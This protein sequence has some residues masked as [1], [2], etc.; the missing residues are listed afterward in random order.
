MEERLG[1]RGGGQ[2]IRRAPAWILDV[3]PAMQMG[4]SDKMYNP[5]FGKDPNLDFFLGT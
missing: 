4:H 3:C 1:L 2:R 5:Y